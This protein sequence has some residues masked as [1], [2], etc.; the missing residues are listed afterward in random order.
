[1]TPISEA[2]CLTDLSSSPDLAGCVTLGNALCLWAALSPHRHGWG[3]SRCGVLGS[4]GRT[5]AGGSGSV[6]SFPL[7]PSGS[8][9]LVEDTD[10]V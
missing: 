10:H 1:M 4:G 7:C 5:P 9:H 8:P 3:T 2:L 6:T